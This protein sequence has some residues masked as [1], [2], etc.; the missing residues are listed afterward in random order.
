MPLLE[1]L[2]EANV[3]V[4]IV[5]VSSWSTR[6]SLLSRQAT[7]SPST[8]QIRPGNRGIGGAQN[9]FASLLYLDTVRLPYVYLEFTQ[10]ARCC[11]FPKL[12]LGLDPAIPELKHPCYLRDLAPEP[13]VGDDLGESGHQVR[14]FWTPCDVLAEK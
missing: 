6:N 2:L 9:P 4:G 13:L 11:M 7:Q 8:P 1:G 3:L 12:C 14:R 10:R 5:G